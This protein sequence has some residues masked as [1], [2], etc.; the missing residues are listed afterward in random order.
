MINTTMDFTKRFNKEMAKEYVAHMENEL[1]YISQAIGIMKE[2][3]S[4]FD[5]KRLTARFWKTINA[6]LAE[7]I[8]TREVKH[9]NGTT[10]LINIV[11]VKTFL[12]DRCISF[13]LFDRGFTLPNDCCPI[14]LDNEISYRIYDFSNYIVDADK[15]ISANIVRRILDR[16]NEDKRR[17]LLQHKDAI[18]NWDE[19]IAKVQKLTDLIRKNAAE[20]NPLFINGMARNLDGRSIYFSAKEF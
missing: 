4:D 14:Y 1:G 16:F 17:T 2:V 10:K 18:Q 8:G 9:D 13:S 7:T 3:A 15:H 5:G 20:I 11:S 6:R 19:Y 12:S